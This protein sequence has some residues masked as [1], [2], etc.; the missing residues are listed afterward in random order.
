MCASSI[1]QDW[2]SE[3]VPIDVAP[4]QHPCLRQDPALPWHTLCYIISLTQFPGIHSGAEEGKESGRGWR[5]AQ[6]LQGL[7][8]HFQLLQARHTHPCQ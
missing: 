7:I 4:V 3:V 8:S 5:W 2:V 1:H 6:G